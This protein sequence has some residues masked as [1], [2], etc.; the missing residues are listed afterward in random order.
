M[1]NIIKT[2]IAWRCSPIIGYQKFLPGKK[3]Y[4]VCFFEGRKTHGL[5]YSGRNRCGVRKAISRRKF[6]HKNVYNFV[7][8]L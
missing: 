5:W 1:E 2:I 4:F 6:N 7:F 8:K 3:E